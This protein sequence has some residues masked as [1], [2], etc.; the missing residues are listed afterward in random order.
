MRQSEF[1]WYGVVP[2]D[3]LQIGDKLDV[4]IISIDE[5]RQRIRL[6][7]RALLAH[8]REDFAKTTKIGAVFHAT[9]H[10]IKEYGVLVELAPGVHGLLHRSMIA[11]ALGSDVNHQTLTKGEVL[12]V[13]IVNMV[14]DGAHIELA[15]V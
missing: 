2:Q 5:E 15:L 4:V 14:T 11:D 1:S 8:P 10:K 7:R 9:V 6:S 12:T 13:R 3:V